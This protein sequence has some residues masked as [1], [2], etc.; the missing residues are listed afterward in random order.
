[1]GDKE[2]EGLPEV[3]PEEGNPAREAACNQSPKSE[4]LGE[5]SLDHSIEERHGNSGSAEAEASKRLLGRPTSEERVQWWWPNNENC[6][7]GERERQAVANIPA[8]TEL[9]PCSLRNLSEP[10]FVAPLLVGEVEEQRKAGENQEID[11]GR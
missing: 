6:D 3:S 9:K 1:M 2:D 5:P 7:S 11:Q 4:F 8:L 10:V